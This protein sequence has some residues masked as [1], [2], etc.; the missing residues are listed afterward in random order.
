MTRDNFSAKTKE[1][2][3]DRAGNRCSYPGCNALTAGPSD[4]GD[5]A[6]SNT[7]T[8]AHITAA[9]AGRGARRYDPDIT[10]EQRASIENGIWC[11]RLHGTLIDTDEVTYSTE[12]LKK[13]RLLAEKRAKIRQA[14]GDVPLTLHP[15]LM[16]MGLPP[17]VLKLESHDDLNSRIGDAVLHGCVED[18]WGPNVGGAIRD[19]LIEC[20]R[21]AFTHSR[22]SSVRISINPSSIVVLHD[23]S[24]FDWTEL[25]GDGAGRG[26]G[27]AYRALLASLR[28]STMAIKQHAEGKTEI[29]IPLLRD[30]TKLPMVNPC[31]IEFNPREDTGTRDIGELTGCNRIYA[32]YSGYASYS[33]VY[34]FHEFL[35]PFKDSDKDV[36]L[37]LK[38]PSQGVLEHFQETF[39][40]FK[41]EAWT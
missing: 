27:M 33:D 17:D 6:V 13:W 12:M 9:A 22:A 10:P 7:G 18:I 11:C 35:R 30:I 29:H 14:I 1:A 23:G 15:E 24:H 26:G 4:E 37:I 16:D 2:L 19:F 41:V 40:N 34:L 28:V 8:A 36:T 39:P 5:E 21:N 38:K 20:A 31:A 3:A 32:I 25:T